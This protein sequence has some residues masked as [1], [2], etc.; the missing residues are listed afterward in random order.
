MTP[1]GNTPSCDGEPQIERRIAHDY[2]CR[3]HMTLI[4]AAVI[5]SGVLASK[6]LLVIRVPL[7]FRYP[8]AVLAS[9][10]VFLLLIR[11]WIWYVSV[12][13][14]GGSGMGGFSWSGGSS[15]GS[16]FSFG[17]SSGGGGSSRGLSGFGGGDS[18]GA[19]ASDSWAGNE[20]AA[21]VAQ[22]SPAPSASGGHWW[23]GKFGGGGGGG[24]D[25][26]WIVVLILAALIACI[27][28]GGIYLVVAAPHIMPEAAA[29]M[30]L[31]GTLTRVSKEHHHNWM[32]G[33]LRSTWIPFLIVLVLATA[34]GWEAHR[35]CPT[36]PR[37][38][39]LLHCPGT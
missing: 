12:R 24:D 9:Y 17:G 22:P 23:S 32:A 30:L 18:G 34:L 4:L 35:Y 11:I 31:A 37:L 26:G 19:G 2:Y 20:A 14:S 15:S 25:D 39:D 36:A 10:G 33:V 28:G 3:F 1:S 16:S 5:A 27:L 7:G 21:L 38:I 8:F 6:C 13:Q 29:Q